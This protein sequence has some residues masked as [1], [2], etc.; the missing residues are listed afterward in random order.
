MNVATFAT[1]GPHVSA[2]ISSVRAR[3]LISMPLLTKMS[4][5]ISPP[6]NVGRRAAS[7]SLQE[8][9]RADPNRCYMFHLTPSVGIANSRTSILWINSA[10]GN[11][12]PT[13]VMLSANR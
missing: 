13:A 1:S 7:V 12:G 9:S 3:V 4:N 6:S 10:E 8:M 11:S 5:G 2:M